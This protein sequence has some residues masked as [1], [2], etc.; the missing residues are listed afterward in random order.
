VA[1]PS[2]WKATVAKTQTRG[3]VAQQPCNGYTP[4]L[5][6]D[7]ITGSGHS[8]LQASDTGETFDSTVFILGT[9]SMA[10]DHL[11]QIAAPGYVACFLDR[12]AGLYKSSVQEIS[13]LPAKAGD[14]SSAMRLVMG[15]NGATKAR[16]AE[17]VVYAGSRRVDIVLIHVF[18]IADNT[19][20]AKA[21]TLETRL[22]AR[23]LARSTALAK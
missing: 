1:H 12:V 5:S 7:V 9:E 21:Q 11:T 20:L 13:K 6:H 19:Q 23:M 18:Q 8:D 10:A 22:A 14:R 2:A 17:D 3:S 15:F 4:S 16:I